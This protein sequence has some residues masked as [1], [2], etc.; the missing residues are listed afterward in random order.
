MEILRCGTAGFWRSACRSVHLRH[1]R[2][3]LPQPNKSRS[4]TFPRSERVKSDPRNICIFRQQNRRKNS[5]KP[6]ETVP[7]ICRCFRGPNKVVHFAEKYSP[8]FSTSIKNEGANGALITKF[9]SARLTRTAESSRNRGAG[10][11][12]L[13]LN[14]FRT[15]RRR[16]WRLRR[17][18]GLSEIERQGPAPGPSVPAYESDVLS[19]SLKSFGL[20]LPRLAFM[21]WPTKKP[22]T[23]WLPS[24]Y[25]CA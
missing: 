6:Q 11:R 25:C 10:R 16:Q 1:P 12:A 3:A 20:P 7:K 13:P 22:M 18:S 23:F 2:K 14:E 17:E 15:N 9:H 5:T 24:R 19:N 4:N 21:H 8:S